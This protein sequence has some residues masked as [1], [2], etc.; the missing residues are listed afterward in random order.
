MKTI[1]FLTS[2]VKVAFA[3]VAVF[4]IAS[5]SKSDDDKPE[6]PAN[7][8][9]IDGITMPVT[10]A[11]TINP[12]GVNEGNYEITLF[13]S[14]NKS[15]TIMASKG[16]HNGKIIDLTK[17]EPEHDGQY[18]GV[19]CYNPKKIFDTFGQPGTQYPVFT[20]GTLY[21]KHLGY[22]GYKPIF[23]IVL[24][25]GKVKGEGE[26]GDG[27]EHTV[28]INWKGSIDFDTEAD[29]L[30]VDDVLMPIISVE[31]IKKNFNE[32]N[33]NIKLLLSEDKKKYIH[34]RM[35]KDHHD[36]KTIDLTK[37][38]HKH[39][40]WNWSV[41]YYNPEKIFD[42]YGHPETSEPVFISGTLYVSLLGY[43][44]DNKPVVFR[45]KLENG[46]VKGEGKYGDGKEHT[47]IINW[48]GMMELK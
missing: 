35:S 11:I 1:H 7:V 40:G 30:I 6:V 47:V 5:C 16:H 9:V 33:Y 37:K 27:K 21:V 28:S 24:K 45:I 10:N 13:L 42:T 32:G 39:S 34:I 18:W 44:S 2:T 3:L 14:E 36:S 20:S 12:H 48:H 25:N 29:Y 31:A 46:K 4:A 41:E 38:E 43:E 17:K 15:I 26:Y 8:I 22:E 19:E 23:E